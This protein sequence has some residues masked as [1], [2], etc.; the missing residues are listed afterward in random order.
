MY[1]ESVSVGKSSHGD[2]LWQRFWYFSWEDE[3]QVSRHKPFI[4]VSGSQGKLKY[5][6]VAKSYL[7]DL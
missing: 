3:H 2:S 1:Q 4:G 5:E 7:R 6:K